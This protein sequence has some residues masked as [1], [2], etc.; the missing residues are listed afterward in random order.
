MVPINLP[1]YTATEEST[2]K[3][4]SLPKPKEIKDSSMQLKTAAELSAKSPLETQT[5]T[6]ISPPKMYHT[7]SDRAVKKPENL[8]L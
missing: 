3:T 1:T 6:S 7:K 5:H 4:S 8:N 2:L